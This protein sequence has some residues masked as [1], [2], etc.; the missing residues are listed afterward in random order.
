MLVLAVRK[1]FEDVAGS[2]FVKGMLLSL[3]GLGLIS[4]IERRRLIS[5]APSLR[6]DGTMS[7]ESTVL[8]MESIGRANLSLLLCASNIALLLAL[9]CIC[10]VMED[11]DALMHESVKL[12]GEAEKV[13]DACSKWRENIRVQEAMDLSAVETIHSLSNR[14]QDLEKELA[15]LREQAEQSLKARRSAEAQAEAMKKQSHGL[16]VEY[17]R[18]IAEM[19][20]LKKKLKKAEGR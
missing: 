13:Q 8:E 6:E 14:V 1:G 16:T 3:I 19:N 4:E 10:K 18:V 9:S 5:N 12:Q 15:S 7:L 20:Q 11:F 17:D 2:Y